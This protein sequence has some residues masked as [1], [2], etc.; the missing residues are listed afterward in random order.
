MKDKEIYKTCFATAGHNA[1]EWHISNI[2]SVL[3]GGLACGLYT[4]SSPEALAY[5]V[6][7]SRADILVI[8]D[9]EQLAKVREAGAGTVVQWEGVPGE[10][11]IS[12]AELLEIGRAESDDILT[13]RMEDQAVNMACMLVYT[14]GTTG[15]CLT[16][17]QKQHLSLDRETYNRKPELCPSEL[18]LIKLGLN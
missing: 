10:G 9:G 1:P 5:K 16:N 17:F 14:S 11:A 4:T 6:T 15:G 12:W 8:E 3:A 7:H 18:S 13:R 2:A